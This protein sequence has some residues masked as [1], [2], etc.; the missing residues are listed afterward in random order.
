LKGGTHSFANGLSVSSN[1]W[2]TGGGTLSGNVTNAGVLA[3]DASFG[4]LNINGGVQLQPNSDIAF[5]IGGYSAGVNYDYISASGSMVWNGR[6]YVTL[7]PGFVP[8]PSD[9]FTI[10]QCAGDSG[11]FINVASGGTLHT[12]DNLGSFVVTYGS[13]ALQLSQYHS[14]APT[15][16]NFKLTVPKA[17]S[18][19]VTLQFPFA[20]G[21]TYHLWFSTNLASWTELLVPGYLLP[22]PGVGQWTDDGSMTG[23]ASFNL[24]SPRFYR[25]SFE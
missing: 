6:L 24:R 22:Q 20:F 19:S 1:A 14:L 3:P 12:A 25:I 9:V 13:S 10:A 21:R 11:S 2:L 16:S 5:D 8:N 23:S 7:T 4:S 17:G 18:G 15:S